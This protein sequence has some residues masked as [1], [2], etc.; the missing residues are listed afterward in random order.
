MTIEDP[1][2]DI[3]PPKATARLSARRVARSTPWGL[4]WARDSDRNVLLVLQY[5]GGSRRSRRLP[6]LRGLRVET[7]EVDGSSD[8]RIVIRLTDPEQREIFIRF[9]EDIVEATALARTEEQAVERFLARTWRWHRLLRSGRESRLRDEEQKGL[10]GELVMLERHLLPVLGALD[11]VRCWT[12][13]LQEPRDFEI[14]RI[15]VEAKARGFGVSHITISSE[16]QLDSN[17]CD[18]LFLH[19]TEVGTAA[20]GASSALTVTEF[21]S[22]MRSEMARHDMAAVD[23][24]EERLSAVGFEWTDDYSDKL[25]LVG[26]ESVYEVQE[27]FPRITSSTIPGGVSNVRYRIHLPE[28]EKFRVE[29]AVLVNTV[30]ETKD[31]T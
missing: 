8:E 15:H 29:P 17:D 23:L 28:C 31:D 16:H 22:K 25:W 6:A 26:R 20:E 3:A 21:A 11:A 10:I 4:Y 19:V 24:F 1:W 13:P 14:S 7:H 30:A 5:G 9:C 12:G 18:T 27:G 2:K